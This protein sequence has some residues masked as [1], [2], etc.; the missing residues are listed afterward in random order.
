MR[1]ADSQPPAR[2]T[3]ANGSERLGNRDASGM[4]SSGQDMRCSGVVPRP[5]RSPARKTMAD[6]SRFPNLAVPFA[7]VGAAAGWLSAG[8]AQHPFVYA[9]DSTFRGVTAAVAAVLAG[10][11][12][13]L[14]RRWCV[15][16]R[17]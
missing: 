4:V 11:T 16:Q 3:I 2:P 8:L 17:Y 15:G 5:S 10:A 6:A 14:L 1:P 13:V 12:G 9:P 7:L